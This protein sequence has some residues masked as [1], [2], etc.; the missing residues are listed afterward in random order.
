FKDEGT[1]TT[2]FD[3]VVLNGVDRFNLFRNAVARLPQL[4]AHVE[5]VRQL[6]HAKLQAHRAYIDEHGEDMPEIVDWQWQAGA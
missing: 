5:E 2:P 6:V 4:A 3:M 1:T